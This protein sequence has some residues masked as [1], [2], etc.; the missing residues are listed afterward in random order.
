MR[1]VQC[2][3]ED[4]SFAFVEDETSDSKLL[5]TVAVVAPS[6]GLEVGSLRAMIRNNREEFEVPRL[7]AISNPAKE[8][9]VAHR[10]EFGITRLRDDVILLTEDDYLMACAM[11]RTDVGRAA[12]KHYVQWQKERA[13]RGYVSMEQFLKLGEELASLRLEMNQLGESLKLQASAAGQTLSLHRHT[14]DIR[15]L[16]N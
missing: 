1:I 14:K 10:K 8:F 16:V 5:T 4:R 3:Y 2:G 12:R 9:I 7:S 15:N 13:R 11:S 6:I